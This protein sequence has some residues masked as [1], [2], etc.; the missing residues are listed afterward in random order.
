MYSKVVHLI[1]RSGVYPVS[2]SSTEMQ[3]FVE[4]SPC[5]TFIWNMWLNI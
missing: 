3:V 5:K 4:G 2:D 1:E